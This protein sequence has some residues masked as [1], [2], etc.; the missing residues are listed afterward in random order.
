MQKMIRGNRGCFDDVFFCGGGQ[1]LEF[2]HA[3][4]QQFGASCPRPDMKPDGVG[5]A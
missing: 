5:S 4:G 2:R 3:P 1:A